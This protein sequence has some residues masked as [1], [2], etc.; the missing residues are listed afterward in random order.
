MASHYVCTGGCLTVKYAP[1]NCMTRGCVRHRNPLTECNCRNSKH[2]DL[3][4][5]NHPDRD[6]ILAEAKAA[7]KAAKLAKKV[8]APKI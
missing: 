5:R 1:G 4:Y 2:G 3:P 6:R 7:A 8:D